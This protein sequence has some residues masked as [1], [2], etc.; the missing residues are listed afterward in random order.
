MN[1][2]QHPD[3][4]HKE[5]NQAAVGHSKKNRYSRAGSWAACLKKDLGRLR[6]EAEQCQNRVWS[7]Y[8]DLL[9]DLRRKT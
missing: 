2:M 1:A 4:V 5:G 3:K 6:Q 9:H 7:R 8:A